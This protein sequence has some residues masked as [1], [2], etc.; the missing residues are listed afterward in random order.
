[1]EVRMRF[2]RVVPLIVAAVLSFNT[3][4]NAENRIPRPAIPKATAQAGP[5]GCVEPVDVMRK[6]HFEFILHQRDETMH[7]GIRTEQ[8][9]LKECI[10]CHVVKKDDGQPVTYESEEHFCKSCH[11]YA[12]VKIDCFQCHASTPSPGP[13]S[14][15]AETANVLD[16]LIKAPAG[17]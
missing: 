12:A 17:K 16:R 13:G 3:A 6:R 2:L 1:M 14:P 4:A 10:D 7:R 15:K 8:H 11:S 9:S 5:E